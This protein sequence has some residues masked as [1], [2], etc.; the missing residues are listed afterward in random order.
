MNAMHQPLHFLPTLRG[1][2]RLPASKSL[3]NRALVIARTA[4]RPA[5]V[6]NLSE[7]D[8]THLLAAA[9]ENDSSE[10]N[11]GAA[12][13]AMRFSTAYFSI[14][15]GTRLLTGTVRMKQRPI[16]ILVD[17]LRSLGADISYAG[18][19]GFPPLRVKGGRLRGGTVALPADVSSQY[20]SAL[21][22][23][24][25]KL[26]GGLT[27]RLQGEVT[28]R[29]YID[30][31]LAL[32]RRFGLQARWTSAQDI[33]VEAVPAASEG[34]K[35]DETGDFLHFDVESDW[36]AASYWFEMVA[37]SPDP[38]ARLVLPGLRADSLQG[39]RRVQEFF[40]PLGV[41]TSFENGGAVLTKCA[42]T[43]GTMEADLSQQPDLAQ[44]LVVTC[45][46]LRRPFRFS[47]LHSLRI[48]ETDRIAALQNELRKLGVEVEAV[49]D[50]ELCAAAYAPADKIAKTADSIA[51]YDDHRMAMSFAPC[52]YRH[53]GLLIAHP[54]VVSKSYPGFW[55]ELRSFEKCNAESSDTKAQSPLF[56]RFLKDSERF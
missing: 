22:M 13:T 44:T 30:M 12:G 54:E 18:R 16:G 17:A 10:I 32:M 24:G 35:F 4:G 52:A 21:L 46:M 45:A 38:A 9:L 29:P 20:I 40:R 48:K 3:S 6:H 49:G 55:T 14:V 1:T 50:Q 39:D 27:L 33:R 11:L 56:A 28:S 47:G 53:P 19:E 51:T 42:P 37:L 23:I 8:D 7:A 25:P 43:A 31:T 2:V 41:A 34:E 5:Q 26:E 36:S 15:P